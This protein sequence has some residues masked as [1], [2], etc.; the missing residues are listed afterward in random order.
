MRA[1]NSIFSVAICVV[2]LSSSAFADGSLSYADLREKFSNQLMFE[3]LEQAVEFSETVH[4]RIRIQ[5]ARSEK[6]AGTRLG[7]YYVCARQKYGKRL[8]VRVI[9]TT[10]NIFVGNDGKKNDEDCDYDAIAEIQEEL[11]G[12]LI[13]GTGSDKFFPFDC[14]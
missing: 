7:P 2:L 3:T 12:V 10:K 9:F 5:S 14:R 6:F 8:P 11:T 13:E 4:A 1:C